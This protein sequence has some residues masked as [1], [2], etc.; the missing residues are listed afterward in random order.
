MF[1]PI[2]AA[3]AAFAFPALMLVAAA[4]DATSFTI[5]NRISVALLGLFPL[6]AFAAGLPLETMA[7]H[8]AV[9]FAGLVAGMV[10]FSLRWVGGGDAKLF[11]AAALWL[12]WPAV[13]TFVLAAAVAG[14]AL[15]MA[16]LTARSTLVRPI[17]LMGPSWVARLAEPGESVPYGVAI[18]AGALWALQ[19]SPFAAVLARAGGL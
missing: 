5:P 8:L 1:P 17:M 7:V 6:A 13:M 10:M 2:A 16:L 15:A 4:K 12:G 14:G 18:A 3:A 9:G 19:A 11:A